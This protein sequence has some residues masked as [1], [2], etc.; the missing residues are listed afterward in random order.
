M[1]SLPVFRMSDRDPSNT[2]CDAPRGDQPPVCDALVPMVRAVRRDFARMVCAMRRSGVGIGLIDDGMALALDRCDRITRGYAC[3]DA[4]ESSTVRAAC[5]EL[6]A[7][8]RALVRRLGPS[9]LAR[10]RAAERDDTD[11]ANRLLSLLERRDQEGQGAGS[12]WRDARRMEEGSLAAG[13]AAE[14]SRRLDAIARRLGVEILERDMTSPSQVRRA[15]EQVERDV[16]AMLLDPG[17]LRMLVATLEE[18]ARRLLRA[19]F[20][21]EVTSRLRA[22]LRNDAR[23]G[24]LAGPGVLVSPIKS[25]CRCGLVFAD[26][27]GLW[28]PAELQQRLRPLL[29]LAGPDHAAAL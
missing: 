12:A 22:H 10:V 8:E 24:H 11:C 28:I 2:S 14:S 5:L 20:R 25:L 18:D 3:G 1:L 17:M 21:D 19:L 29:G 26:R 7:M 16:A 23:T 4:I 6:R 15:R 27:S 13:L 9:A